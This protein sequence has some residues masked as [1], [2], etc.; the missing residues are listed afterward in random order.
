MQLT[1]LLP[2][3][4]VVNAQLNTLAQKAGLKYF[5][6]ASDIVDVDA[7][8]G[9]YA[10]I[11]SDRREFGAV[12]PANGMKWFAIEPSP[13]VFNF[14]YGDVVADYAARNKQYL[15]CHTLVWH[16][17]LPPWVENTNWTKQTLTAVIVRHITH[18]VTHYK[19]R[20][21]A[22][23]VVNEALNEDGTF[24]NSTFYNILG[25][26]FL[27]LA[28]RTAHA[29]DPRAKLYYNDYNLEKPSPKS[30]AVINKIVK[31]LLRAG[32]PIYGVGMQAHLK[33]YNRPSRGEMVD[34]MRAYGGL[35]V[36]VGV[37]ELDV[38]ILL[39]ST[40]EKMAEQSTAYADITSACV[41]VQ[42]CIGITV[43]DFWDPVSWVP[44]VFPGEGDATLYYAN[45]TRHP[46]YEGVVGA[47]KAGG[48][49]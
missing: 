33:G 34:V 17:Q 20:C 41:E 14:S 6:S 26:S 23:D 1:H 49:E 2:L 35:G 12:T 40:P 10:S 29:A 30:H 39:P 28:F 45:F 8:D 47:L 18:T 16:S 19:N 25:S 5:G 21:Y 43:W 9:T 22:W 3:L 46:A 48:R 44:G 37:T 31:P 15:R 27:S 11:L 38:R 24:R 13:G 7:L 32:V 4:I 36:E 42:A